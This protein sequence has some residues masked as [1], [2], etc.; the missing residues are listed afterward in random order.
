MSRRLFDED[1]EIDEARFDK[2]ES[3]QDSGFEFV[4][5]IEGKYM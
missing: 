4:D 2:A 1:T 5:P 3:Q